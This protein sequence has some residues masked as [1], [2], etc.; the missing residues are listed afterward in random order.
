[1]ASELSSVRLFKNVGGI[2]DNFDPIHI[3]DNQA[4]DLL[5]VYFDRGSICKRPGSIKRNKTKVTLGT[6]GWTGLYDFQSQDGSTRKFIACTDDKVYYWKDATDEWQDIS[7]VAFTE[8]YWSFATFVNSSAASIAILTNGNEGVRKWTG[9][10]NVA[11]LGGSPPFTKA[12]YLAVHNNQLIAANCYESL[13]LPSRVRISDI[14]NGESWQTNGYIDIAED[15]DI[16]TGIISVKDMLVIFERDHI[17]L[18]NGFYPTNWTKHLAVNGVGCVAPRSIQIIESPQYGR[19]IVYLAEDGLHIYQGGNSS[20]NISR[21][22]IENTVRSL[23]DLKIENACSANYKKL[24]LYLLWVPT[25]SSDENN[26]LIV[27][28]YINNAFSLWDIPASSAA[29][30]ENPSTDVPELFTG[31]YQGFVLKQDQGNADGGAGDNGTATAAGATTLTDSTKAWTINEWQGVSVRIMAGTGLGQER[32]IVSNTATQ[33]TVAAW[34]ANPDT[35]SQYS[36]GF[37]KAHYQTKWFDYGVPE[38][39]KGNRKL[40]MV[41]A[42]E[43]NYDLEVWDKLDFAS[44][45]G[46]RNTINLVASGDLL[47]STFILG[48]SKLGGVSAFSKK[49]SMNGAGKFIQFKFQTLW[50]NQPFKIHGWTNHIKPLGLGE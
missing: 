18:A 43:G 11:P 8:A 47:G 22:L 23:R 31:D 30:V 17:Y 16:I 4:S 42:Q 26:L 38:R 50:E 2:N 36:I 35:S 15:D 49:I 32:V 46:A 9:S 37:I 5:N 27:Y 29:I 34:A 7:D 40:E 6:L 45:E 28:D 48:T 20:P 44:G 24:G 19:A 21:I 14:K 39:R 12:K 25:G 3:E 13:W 1:M 10:G 33:L 41:L